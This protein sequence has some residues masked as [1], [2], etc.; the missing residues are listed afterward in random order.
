MTAG[1]KDGEKRMG[2]VNAKPH[3]LASNVMA[4]L[5]EGS[6]NCPMVPV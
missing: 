6:K 1:E 5:R 3:A 2:D 4:S